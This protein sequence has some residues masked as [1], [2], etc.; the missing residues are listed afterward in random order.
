MRNNNVTDKFVQRWGTQTL[1]AIEKIV[2]GSRPKNPETV[3]SY[4]A[5]R[6]NIT[7]GTYSGFIQ[8][9]NGKVSVNK[10][11]LKVSNKFTETL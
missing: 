7:R 5:Y 1:R 9:R 4:A 3:R 6:A 11:G 10:L 2:S 8:V